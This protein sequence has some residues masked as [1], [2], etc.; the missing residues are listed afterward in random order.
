MTEEDLT[1]MDTK[2]LP[3]TI[4]KEEKIS[5][6][7]KAEMEQQI[8]LYVSTPKSTFVWQICM[9]QHNTILLTSIIIFIIITQSF[10]NHI[11]M[12]SMYILSWKISRGKSIITEAAITI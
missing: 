12:G 6:E 7:R 11:H 2:S 8:S 4:Q 1:P 10:W 3:E 5:K 9:T